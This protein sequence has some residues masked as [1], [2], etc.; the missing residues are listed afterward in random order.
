MFEK[1]KLAEKS[2]PTGTIDFIHLSHD[3]DT[4]LTPSNKFVVRNMI[5]VPIVAKTRC[6]VVRKMGLRLRKR[7]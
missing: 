3:M 1:I 6:H 5:R 2:A 4:E 7:K